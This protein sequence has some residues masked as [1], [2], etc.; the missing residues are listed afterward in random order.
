MNDDMKRRAHVLAAVIALL[1]FNTYTVSYGRQPQQGQEDRRVTA[2]MVGD[3]LA[4]DRILQD[5]RN[6]DGSYDFRE[7]FENVKPAVEAADIAIVNQETILGGSSL[8][9]TGYPSFNSPYELADAEADAG[10]DVIL[11]GTNHALDRGPKGIENCL[12]YW[13]TYHPGIDVV[14]IH[15]SE[16]DRQEICIRECNGIRIAV[17]NYTYGTNGIQMPKGKGYL[18]DYLSEKRV[19]DDILAAKAVSDIVMVCPHW[20]DEYKTG[21]SR[22]QRK[23]ARI[24]MESGAD[25]VIGTHPHV[26]EPFELMR[27]ETGRTMPVYYSIGNF[28]NATSGKGAG[29]MNRMVGGM[30]YVSIIKDS[31]G[32]AAISGTAVRPVVCHLGEGRTGVYF[33][34]DYTEEMA[35]ANMIRLQDPSFSKKACI[36]LVQSIWPSYKGR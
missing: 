19:R 7:L 15:D 23:W 8:K 4:H 32:N 3:V 18:V 5:S 28:V 29:V 6:G 24:F 1:V 20:G 30:V 10:F 16:E 14:G 34:D 21:V 36:E 12:S 11:Q 13:E 2:V 17:L 25:I 35:D 22:D 27:D 33:L 9:Y 26:I 31:N